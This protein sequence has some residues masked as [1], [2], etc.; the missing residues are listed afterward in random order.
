M[1]TELMEYCF[2]TWHC[3]T[4]QMEC[5]VLWRLF[6]QGRFSCHTI[7]PGKAGKGKGRHDSGLC[8]GSP[9]G[10]V[11]DSVAGSDEGK[12][13][14]EHAARRQFPNLAVQRWAVSVHIMVVL[15][16]FNHRLQDM[17]RITKQLT[18]SGSVVS[19]EID[20]QL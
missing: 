20:P 13:P 1:R 12:C 6:K 5:N 11:K 8:R 16:T 2:T 3:N 14:A 15:G 17:R 4:S 10:K 9:L 18:G 19:T 7:Q